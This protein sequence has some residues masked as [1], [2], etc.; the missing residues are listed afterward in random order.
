[1]MQYAFS[2]IFS[3][4]YIYIFSYI[5]LNLKLFLIFIYINNYCMKLYIKTINIITIILILIF[6]TLLYILHILMTC[7]CLRFPLFPLCT[8]ILSFVNVQVKNLSTV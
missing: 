8:T 1:M 3:Y 4:I 5:F 2:C 6:Y 7:A